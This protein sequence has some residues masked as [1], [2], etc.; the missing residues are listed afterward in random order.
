MIQKIDSQ[1]LILLS[2][3]SF[4]VLSS[5]WLFFISGKYMNPDYNSDWW[6]I[7]FENPKSQDLSFVIENHSLKTTFQWKVIREESVIQE[8]RLEIPR[9]KTK[10]IPVDFQAESN[11][12]III[13]VLTDS[14]TK[15]IYKNF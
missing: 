5:F 14:E 4:F 7:Y 15:E 11:E 8:G 2:I 1:K 12:K 9:G 10:K 6:A 13:Q 3:I